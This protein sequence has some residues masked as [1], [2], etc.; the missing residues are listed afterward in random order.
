M[1]INSYIRPLIRWWRLVVVVTMLAVISSAVSTLF[2]PA[3][4]KSRTTLVIGT[5]I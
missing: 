1:E 4:Y 5:T 3:L 2:Q